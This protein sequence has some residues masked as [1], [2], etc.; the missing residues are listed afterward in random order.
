MYKNTFVV[1]FSQ[2]S[3]QFLQ[4][5][6]QVWKSASSCN[7]EEYLD[8]DQEADDFY[9]LITSSLIQL[10]SGRSDQLF[11][12]DVDNKHANKQTKGKT[13][14]P[15]APCMAEV[16]NNILGVINTMQPAIYRT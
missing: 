15:S 12:R 3:D 7:L 2:T 8:P 16:I 5:Y 10:C 13:Y 11:L 14:P 9:N 6:K 4:T 1:K